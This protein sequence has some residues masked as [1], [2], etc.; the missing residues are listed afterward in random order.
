MRDGFAA[1]EKERNF[2][3][4]KN[5]CER[6]VIIFKIAD[7]NRAIAETV[8]VA[9]EFQNLARGENGFGFGIRASGEFE[10]RILRF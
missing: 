1:V 3:A 9:D 5:A 8:A 6:L 10:T 4:A 2:V 7:K